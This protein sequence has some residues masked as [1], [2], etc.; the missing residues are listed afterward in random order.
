VTGTGTLTVSG[1]HT[2][3]DPGSYAVSVQIS[4]KLGDT[5]KATVYPTATVTTLG[6]EVKHGLT[7]DI[8]FW[9][10]TSG[11]ALI[12]SFNGG[13]NAT[14]L[15]TWLATSFPNLYGFLSGTANSNVAVYYQSLF[16][17]TGSNAQANVLATALNVYATTQSL[18]GTGGQ[19]NGFTVTATGL[20]ADSFNVGFDG[21]AFGVPDKTT[22]NVY[23]LL[24]AVNRL[25]S[26]YTTILWNQVADLLSALNQA[27]A[28][29]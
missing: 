23:E 6:Q 1:P 27:G 12:N 3:A 21:A 11:Q 22:L 13:P 5:I 8:G 9:H 4:H 26:R 28:I 16:N 20:G 15:S 7:G 25:S 17:L 10:N 2:Y 24:Q 29:S 14:T 19:A 18:G